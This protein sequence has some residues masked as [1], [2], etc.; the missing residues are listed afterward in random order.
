LTRR[1]AGQLDQREHLL[2]AGVG[3]ADGL[4]EHPQ[5][6]ARRTPRVK[7]GRLEY[8]P[9]PQR[10]PVELG[11]GAVEHE[12][13]PAARRGESQHHPQRRRLAGAVGAEKASDRAGFELE[14]QLV[15]RQH[16]AEAFRQRLGYDDGRYAVTRLAGVVGGEATR[17]R[18]GT[19][20]PGG[21]TGRTT[22]LG[23][24]DELVIPIDRE[25][26]APGAGEPR[27]VNWTRRGGD[28]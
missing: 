19:S 28:S 6:V 14:R 24:C 5:V 25:L 10:R 12:R 8:R 23:R 16:A 22:R 7:V 21:R 18:L 15:Y 20:P 3:H 27:R 2:D 17:H 26:S 4:P 1:R 11:V 9:D 13:P